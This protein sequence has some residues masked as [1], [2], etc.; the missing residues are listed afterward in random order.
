MMPRRAMAASHQPRISEQKDFT[1]LK[2]DHYP[3]SPPLDK[4]ASINLLGDSHTF[5]HEPLH[6]LSAD[7]LLQ[8]HAEV[9]WPVAQELQYLR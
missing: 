7:Q 6:T 5:S 9:K 3:K 2:V 4:P 1:N 8:E